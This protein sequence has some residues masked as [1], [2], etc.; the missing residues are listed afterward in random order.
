MI[1]VDGKARYLRE[2]LAIAETI[3]RQTMLEWEAERRVRDYAHRSDDAT[4]IVEGSV[5]V[6]TA[7]KVVD[8]QS[9]GV[10]KPA[11]LVDVDVVPELEQ[12]TQV[13]CVG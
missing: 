1:R 7:I 6:S 8:E 9:A 4:T 11:E 12:R 3:E 5:V 13:G 10:A 2:T